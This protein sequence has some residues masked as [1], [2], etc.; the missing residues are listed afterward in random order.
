MGLVAVFRDVKNQRALSAS[1]Y[2]GGYE[3]AKILKSQIPAWYAAELER[4]RGYY[5]GM[6]F[7]KRI[8]LHWSVQQK[9]NEGT[10]FRFRSLPLLLLWPLLSL[11]SGSFSSSSSR[12]RH[13][14][15]IFP[16]L[17]TLQ[18]RTFSLE[19]ITLINCVTSNIIY[20]LMT[21]N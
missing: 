10:A 3:G 13:A 5:Y 14:L 12:W 18:V 6:Y 17:P 7:H 20:S 8:S 19:Y 15:E 21:E 2:R 11:L 16:W 9:M 1:G 4:A